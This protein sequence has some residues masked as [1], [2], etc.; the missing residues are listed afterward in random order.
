[1]ALLKKSV[2]PFDWCQECLTRQKVYYDRV[3]FRHLC[4]KCR[5]ELSAQVE[6]EPLPGVSL[7][8]M[9]SAGQLRR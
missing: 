8:E 1:M 4:V 2:P 3:T 5:G 6:P 9:R 7:H